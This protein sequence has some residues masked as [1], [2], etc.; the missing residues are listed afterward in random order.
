MLVKPT[1]VSDITDSGQGAVNNTL[2][3]ADF[4]LLELKIPH[5]RT[6]HFFRRW[7]KTAI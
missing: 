4:R 3:A 5:L 2:A 1:D 6:H 7:L